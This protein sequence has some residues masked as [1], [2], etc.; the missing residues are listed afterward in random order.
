MKPEK[1]VTLTSLVCVEVACTKVRLNSRN[2]EL[3]PA[4]GYVAVPGAVTFF[5]TA[6]L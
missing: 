6:S 5:F 4:L 1:L 2:L 3:R